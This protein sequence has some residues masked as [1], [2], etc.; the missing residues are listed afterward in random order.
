MEKARGQIRGIE[1]SIN[2]YIKEM[3]SGNYQIVFFIVPKFNS[4]V[5]KEDL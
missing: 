1:I 5:K 3:L 4:I 2:E